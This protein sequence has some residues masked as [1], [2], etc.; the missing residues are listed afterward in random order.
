MKWWLRPLVHTT[1]KIIRN[2][3]NFKFWNG[4]NFNGSPMSKLGEQGK[5]FIFWIRT[6][7]ATQ[8]WSLTAWESSEHWISMQG[9]VWFPYKMRKE[10]SG[11]RIC[12]TKLNA[13]SQLRKNHTLM[14]FIFGHPSWGAN[15]DRLWGGFPILPWNMGHKND[16]WGDRGIL[17][18]LPVPGPK[19]DQ[20]SCWI[21]ELIAW[22]LWPSLAV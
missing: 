9:Q 7:S 19:A 6:F 3:K 10:S 15:G 16:G 18:M 2:W 5:D 13:I 11:Q 12:I 21:R 17:R 14:G 20:A 8:Q 22:V 4:H 1:F